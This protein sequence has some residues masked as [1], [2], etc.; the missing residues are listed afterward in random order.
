MTR[1]NIMI[2]NYLKQCAKKSHHSPKFKK[3]KLIQK[4]VKTLGILYILKPLEKF[5]QPYTDIKSNY[6]IPHLTS[7]LCHL[8]DYCLQ[9]GIFH[10][11]SIQGNGQTNG[12]LIFQGLITKN[13][14]LSRLR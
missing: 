5:S 13:Q 7:L 9:I 4:C 11:K 2:V 14:S 8:F 12:Q 1:S 6:T 3:T 10:L